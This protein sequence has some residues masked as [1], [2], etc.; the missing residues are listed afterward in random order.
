MGRII[1]I[2]LALL[3]AVAVFNMARPTRIIMEVQTANPN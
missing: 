1:I 3:I 2:V